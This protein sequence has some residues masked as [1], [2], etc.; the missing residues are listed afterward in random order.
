MAAAPQR[1]RV[2]LASASSGRLQT[3]RHA[4]IDPEVIVSGVDESAIHADTPATLV[5]KLA[6]AKGAAVGALLAPNEHA[7]VI[8]CDSMLELDGHACGKPGT[9]E[10]AHVQW[11]AMRGRTGLLHTGHHV[12]LQR[13]REQASDTRVATTTVEF[14][15]V[16]DAEIDAYI[17]TGEPLGVAGAF[18]IDGYGGAFVTRMAG[19]PHNVV[20]LSLPLLRDLLADLGVAYTDLWTHG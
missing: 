8:A 13:G 9:P 5:G 3:L 16:S 4:G 11:R 20:G 6:A 12:L 1:F 10:R 17:A 19:D 2:I 18:T 14:A 15:D 7:L